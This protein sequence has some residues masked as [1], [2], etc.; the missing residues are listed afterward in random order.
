LGSAALYFGISKIADT[1]LEQVI[2]TAAALWSVLGIVKIAPTPESVAVVSIYAALIV[3]YIRKAL[4]G[5]RTIAKVAILI[6]L[7]VAIGHGLSL[8]GSGV[9]RWRWVIAE[10][11]TVGASAVISRKLVADSTERLH[12]AVLAGL[13]YLSSLVVI[14]N[15]LEPVWPPL[16]TAAYAIF[17]AGLLIVSRQRGGERVL[18]QLG[19][20]TTV[21]VVARL[22]LVDM[23]SVETIWRVLLFLVCGGVFLYAGYRLQP[24]RAAEASK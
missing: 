1:E 13:T 17:G 5:P 12:G 14:M 2:F 9:L 11:V 22:L 4:I 3:I 19:G 10:L 6:S 18:R 7:V 8:P 15:V 20:V 23:A 16:V 21:I 24:P